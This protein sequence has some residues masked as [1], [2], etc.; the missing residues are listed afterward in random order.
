ME[1][2]TTPNTESVG[3][4]KAERVA[5]RNAPRTKLPPTTSPMMRPQM[6]SPKRCPEKH[7]TKPKREPSTKDLPRSP[8]SPAMQPAARN[9]MRLT[10]ISPL[11]SL[12]ISTTRDHSFLN[13]PP[14]AK[15]R[16]VIY[17]YYII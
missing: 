10:R 12:L 15:E 5:P 7:A 17:F 9:A 6:K 11:A 1:S 4:G 14:P 3:S 2:P 13:I 16:T 8:E